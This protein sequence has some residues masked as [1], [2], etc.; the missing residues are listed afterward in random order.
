MVRTN[1][2][3]GLALV[4]GLVIGGLT[5]GSGTASAAGSTCGGTSAVT[6]VTGT[7]TDGAKWEIQCPSGTWNGTLLLYSHGYV[8]PGS[9]NPARDV[10]DSATGGYLLANGFALAG[11]SYATTGWAIQQALP[12]QIG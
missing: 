4:A 8:A 10:G 3:V 6:T 1:K 9:P 7:L 5:A 12:D 2:L 11:S